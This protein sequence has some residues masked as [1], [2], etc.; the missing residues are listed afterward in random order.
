MLQAIEVLGRIAGRR[1]ELVHGPRVEG[2]VRRTAADTSRIR[3]DLGW[4]ARTPFE[5]GLEAQWRW[6]ADRVAAP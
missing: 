4:E 5:E 1:L 3:A 2:D 6:A